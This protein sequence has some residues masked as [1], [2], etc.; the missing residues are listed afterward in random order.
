[1]SHP[2]LL[3]EMFSDAIAQVEMPRITDSRCALV[4]DADS[5][6]GSDSVGGNDV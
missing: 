5:S 3:D 1:M 2:L 4:G 6:A